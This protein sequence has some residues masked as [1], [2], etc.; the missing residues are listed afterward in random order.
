MCYGNDFFCLVNLF[1]AEI[2]PREDVP[3]ETG[4]SKSNIPKF[5]W[6]ALPCAVGT[7]RINQPDTIATQVELEL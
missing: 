4:G 1:P 3:R 5:Y 6:S 2:F 7:S